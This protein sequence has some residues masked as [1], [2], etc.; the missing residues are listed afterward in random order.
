MGQDGMYLLFIVVNSMNRFVKAENV[1]FD[2]IFRFDFGKDQ[3]YRT[4]IDL[5]FIFDL[6][7]LGRKV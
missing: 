4:L 5:S 3:R 7:I 1:Q 6:S 2:D